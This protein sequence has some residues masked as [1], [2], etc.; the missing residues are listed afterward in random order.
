[1]VKDSR[2]DELMIRIS[3]LTVS[4]NGVR[5]VDSINLTV[6]AG[7]IH[8]LL[9]LNGAGK[10]TTIKCIVGLL[11]PD[12]VEELKIAGIDVLKDQSY[13]SLV[14]Y[15]P[16]APTL[17]EYLTPREF[18]TYLAKIR[19]VKHNIRDKVEEI[20][21][22]FGL[23]EVK[24]KLIAD[25]SKG[26]RQRLALASAFL[27]EPRVIVLD[28]PFIGLDPEGQLLVKKLLG[29][30]TARGGAALISTHMLDTAERLCNRITIIHKGRIIATKP[31]KEITEGKPLEEVF[32]KLIGYE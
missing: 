32:F 19:D 15:L 18:L 30:I 16:E 21:D 3:N 2:Q 4:Y 31:V 9:G 12:Y 6:G 26:L 22:L 24:D 17:P 28:E 23:Q 29:K 10:T 11:K 20:M 25:L 13:K 5:A 8:G 27:H 7:E 1:M 14:G